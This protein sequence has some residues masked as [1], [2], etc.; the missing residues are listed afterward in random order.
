VR[1]ARNF[2]PLV[3]VLTVL[4][5]YHLLPGER[6]ELEG[7]RGYDQSRARPLGRPIKG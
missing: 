5:V 2:M 6:A 7:R 1:E 4:T 3:A